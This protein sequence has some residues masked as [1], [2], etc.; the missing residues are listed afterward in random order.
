MKLGVEITGEK[1]KREAG[2]ETS[3][4]KRKLEICTPPPCVINAGLVA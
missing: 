3:S 1:N 4:E 2:K